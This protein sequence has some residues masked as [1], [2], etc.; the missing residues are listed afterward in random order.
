[1]SELFD[2]RSIWL[3][4][5]QKAFDAFVQS[6]EFLDLG[7]RL[8][9]MEAGTVDQP[10]PMRKSTANTY[11][12]MFGNFFRWLEK[13]AHNIA[14]L[15]VTSD[16]L[17]LFLDQRHDDDRDKKKLNSTIRVRYL[18]LLERV[19]AHLEIDPNPARHAAFDV[20]KQ[21]AGGKDVAKVILTEAQQQAFLAALPLRVAVNPYDDETAGWKQRRDRAMQAMMLGAGLKVSEVIGLYSENVGQKE[22]H[23]FDSGYDFAGVGRRCG[24]LAPDPVAPVCGGG[25]GAMVERTK[26][27]ENPWS[28]VVSG[29]LA[30]R[31]LEQ[32][33]GLP[34]DQGDVCA[35]RELRCRGRVAGRCA[36]HLRIGSW[37][38]G[39]RLSWWGSFWGTACAS[40]RKS[41]LPRYR[42]KNLQSHRKRV[43]RVRVKIRWFSTMSGVRRL[44]IPAFCEPM[45]LAGNALRAPPTHPQLRFTSFAVVSLREDLHLQECAH[46][47]RTKKKP[48]ARA[49]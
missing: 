8:P 1:M 19:F 12:A 39:S 24:A 30:G 9:E 4:Q 38:R 47:G 37:W 48:A 3:S 23:R 33:D 13:S 22:S 35:G 18:R 10:R 32:G 36:I 31:S 34:P 41:M 6:P 42:P 28:A 45:P 20:Y 7:R 43:R 2:V 17:R 15:A 25:G 11:R 16:H 27:A 5:P 26:G 40:R 14:F 21:A 46:A 29:D 44:Q 49:G